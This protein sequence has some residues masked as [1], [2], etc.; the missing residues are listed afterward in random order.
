M[1]PNS[2]SAAFANIPILFVDENYFSPEFF[3]SENMPISVLK[4]LINMT[5]EKALLPCLDM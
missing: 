1:A 5:W 3:F 2:P 4:A